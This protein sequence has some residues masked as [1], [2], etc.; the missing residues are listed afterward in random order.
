MIRGCI[1]CG[2]ARLH[3]GSAIVA[4]AVPLY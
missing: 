2:A 1:A 4:A 3:R